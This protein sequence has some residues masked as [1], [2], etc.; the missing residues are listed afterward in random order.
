M[1]KPVSQKLS[2]KSDRKLAEWLPFATHGDSSL[3]AVIV[4]SYNVELRERGKFIGD[5]ANKGALSDVIN[6]RRKLAQKNGRDPLGD[7]PT[8]KLSKKRLEKILA[9]GDAAAAGVVQATLDDFAERLVEVVRRF[10]K[11]P[12][13]KNVERI[14]IGGGLRGGRIGELMIG[15]AQ[16]S[17]DSQKA[18]IELQPIRADPDD[19]GL[20]GAAY[21]AP[22]WIFAGY[23]GILAVDIGG[24]NIRCGLLQFKS[25]RPDALLKPKVIDSLIWEH[26]GE[27]I[28]RNEAVARLV[29]MLQ[30]LIRN[31]AKDRFRLAPFIGIGCPGRVRV[32]GAI[33]RG[34]QNLPGNWEAERF[35]L[36]LHLRQN[37]SI[38]P[39]QETVVIVHN[40]AVVQGLSELPFMRD[41][42]HWAI[43]T[44]GTGLGNAKFTTRFPQGN[45]K[46][47]GKGG[48]RVKRATHS[49]D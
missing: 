39:S 33:D 27:E 21:L 10:L 1:P 40:D 14:A 47:T 24:T 6:K 44:I 42:K 16:A 36:P 46:R 26:A 35:N 17:L 4:E 2:Q 30:K 13:W 5:R 43:L 11:I 22:S 48:E 9:E 19:A 18:S 34:A 12:E 45:R 32:D 38:I 20:I 3:P 28:N 15:R 31:A 41:V 23:D 7:T 49:R 8:D 37:V 29:S 25:A